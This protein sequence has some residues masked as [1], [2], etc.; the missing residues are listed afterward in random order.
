M[1]HTITGSI[2]DQEDSAIFDFDLQIIDYYQCAYYGLD[3]ML[4]S[5]ELCQITVIL[6][7]CL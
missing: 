2:P 1:D 3:A 7:E 6:Y 4:Y 5:I